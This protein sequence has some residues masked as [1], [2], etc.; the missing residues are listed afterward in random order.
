[1]ACTASRRARNLTPSGTR[2]SPCATRASIW[3]EDTAHERGDPGTIPERIAKSGGGQ[4]A[5]NAGHE[6]RRP[7]QVIGRQAFREPVV[8]GAEQR[9]ALGAC[10]ARCQQLSQ[11][12]CGAELE[13]AAAAG[14]RHLEAPAHALLGGLSI[15]AA[16][17]G[18][19]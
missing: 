5:L 15:A 11:T 10:T 2:T 13:R 19:A 1:M 6:C 9:P 8:N 3:A 17:V 7:A 4:N 16:A 18:R 14:P 12:E